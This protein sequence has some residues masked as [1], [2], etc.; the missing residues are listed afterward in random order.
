MGTHYGPHIGAY[1]HT[2]ACMGEYGPHIGWKFFEKLFQTNCPMH[3]NRSEIS[4][5]VSFVQH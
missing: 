4:H 2:W 3:I 5:Y 1:G